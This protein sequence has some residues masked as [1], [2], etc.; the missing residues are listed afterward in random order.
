MYVIVAGDYDDP[1]NVMSSRFSGV[2]S[3]SAGAQ[4]PVAVNLVEVVVPDKSLEERCAK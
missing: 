1:P 2:S 3:F 4:E